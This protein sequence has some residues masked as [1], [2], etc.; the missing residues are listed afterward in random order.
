MMGG[1]A[2][3]RRGSPYEVRDVESLHFLSYSCTKRV[4]R[5]I[6]FHII[7]PTHRNLIFIDV[8][9]ILLGMGGN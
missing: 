5:V 4:N 3:Q 8:L 1:G 7:S 2:G 9:Y 6:C